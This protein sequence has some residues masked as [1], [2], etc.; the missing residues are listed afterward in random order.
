MQVAAVSLEEGEHEA[1]NLRATEAEPESA[2]RPAS[3]KF[4]YPSGSRPLEG[5]TIKRGVGRG[6][7]GEVYYATSDAGKEVA[8]KLIR[9]NLDVELRGVTQ[10]LNLKHPNLLSLFDVK[11]DEL[12]DSWVVME[13][14]AG[15][16]LEAV[17]QRHPQGLPP[18]EVLRWFRGIAAGVCY[19]HDHGIVHRDLKP[20]NIFCDEGIVKIGDYGLSKF[21]SASRRS[22]QTESVGTVHYMAPEI[23]N[24]RYGKEID[25]YA[26]GIILYEMLT[27]H[28]PFEGESVGEVLMKHLTAEPNLE[29]VEE[30]Y[31]SAIAKTLTKNP[32]T[33]IKTVG[34]LLALLPATQ[35][36]GGEFLHG[37]AGRPSHEVAPNAI[38]GVRNGA[39]EA[40]VPQRDGVAGK[41]AGKNCEATAAEI[42]PAS[43]VPEEPVWR[44]ISTSWQ[45]FSHQWRN[46]QITPAAKAV[47]VIGTIYG[48]FHFALPA[49]PLAGLALAVYAIYYVVRMIVLDS[50]P[51]TVRRPTVAPAQA[52]PIAS[53][54]LVSAP[55]APA[56]VRRVPVT[57]AYRST[58]AAEV[59]SKSGRQRIEELTGSLLGAT[60]VTAVMSV[61]LSVVH[62]KTLVPGQFA[63]L[64]LV[65]TLGSWLV[66]TPSKYWEGRTGEPMLRRLT[67]MVLGLG[68]G[69][70]AWGVKDFLLV[71]LRWDWQVPAPAIEEFVSAR[72]Y[73]PD[74]SPTLVGHMGYFAFLML[75][76]GWWKQA[77][78]M[79]PARLRVWPVAVTVFWAWTLYFFSAFPQPWGMMVAASMSIAVQLAASWEK[80]KRRVST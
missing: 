58:P 52:P 23:G 45:R 60:A 26:L 35:G 20:G 72:F 11:Q 42:V 77:D 31:R 17:L 8:L 61:F 34:E 37:G 27:G 36:P 21:I 50:R 29:G 30:P 80:G 6:G 12:G 40:A 65:S 39:A 14:V 68:L 63:W 47:I 38:D 54:V 51:P 55:P 69:A 73:E 15:D 78:P 59:P 66:L 25:I 53:A 22:G 48:M 1:M 3:M 28:V 7:F 4:T 9:R 18:D 41:A 67:L 19:L 13:Y 74:G 44:A 16:S 57:P 64:L 49:I 71:P 33:R 79:R 70:A 76:V 56:P 75:L 5:Y 62:T 10:C 2:P 46:G 43:V 24:G 32:D